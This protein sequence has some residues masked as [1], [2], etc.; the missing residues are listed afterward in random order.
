MRLDTA[1]YTV[2]DVET[3]GLYPYSGDR[4]CEIGAVRFSPAGTGVRKFH[5]LVDPGRPVSPG[6][7]SVNGITDAMLKGKPKI[8]AVMPEFLDFIEGSVLVA[9]NAGFDLGFIEAGLGGRSGELGRFRVID[10]LAL[11][12]R[13]F[14][15]VR[16]YNLASVAQ[17]L[18]I[19][20]G[21]GHRALADALITMKIFKAELEMLMTDGDATLEAISRPPAPRPSAA[22]C[23]TLELVESA[24]RRKRRLEIVYRSS[25]NGAVT[26]RSVTPVRVERG[27][28]RAYVVAHCHMRGLE[29]NFRLDCILEAVEEV[30]RAL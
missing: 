27:Y 20:T 5:R 11:A 4:I 1:S 17:S 3:T 12:R 16:R 2:F 6:A 26:R 22:R 15:E 30:A 28:D 19:D 21:G 25:W 23:R 9:Y 14:P 29:R 18:G 13:L 8:D 10:A 7:F 24:I